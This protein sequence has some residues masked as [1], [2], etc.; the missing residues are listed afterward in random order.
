MCCGRG[1]ENTRNETRSIG[2][3]TLYVF[4]TECFACTVPTH[5]KWLTLPISEMTGV[6]YKFNLVM[7]IVFKRAKRLC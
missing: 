2:H 1:I 3:H 7:S 5:D 4:T 6:G